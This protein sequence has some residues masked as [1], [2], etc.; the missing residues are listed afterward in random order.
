M[1]ETVYFLLIKKNANG[2][3]VF[4]YSG[5]KMCA[6]LY[7]K[8]DGIGSGSHVSLFF[9]I[10]KGQFDPILSWPFSKKVTLKL[11]DQSGRANHLSVC[12]IHLRNSQ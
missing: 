12:I 6:R 3:L 5:Y 8:G 7:P 9:V 2:Y 10:M 4:Y 11:L 1:N